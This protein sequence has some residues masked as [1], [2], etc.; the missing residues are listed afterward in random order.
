M[1]SKDVNK[2]ALRDQ[3]CG[4]CK[5]SHIGMCRYTNYDDEDYRGTPQP[6]EGTCE[7][8][9]LHDL[10]TWTLKLNRP[11]TWGN[12]KVTGVTKPGNEPN[13]PNSITI[14][15]DHDK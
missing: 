9:E 11:Q 1:A 15:F 7:H 6:D 3:T 10:N 14:E 4:N 13:R 5:Y 12:E 2:K 8:W